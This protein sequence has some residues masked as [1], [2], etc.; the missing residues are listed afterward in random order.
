MSQ[1]LDERI[2]VVEGQIK[3][4]ATI[5]RG[6]TITSS[7]VEHLVSRAG[8]TEFEVAKTGLEEHYNFEDALALEC[9]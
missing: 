2:S 9:S 4:R 8:T 5:K 7:T 6:R 1:D 3:A